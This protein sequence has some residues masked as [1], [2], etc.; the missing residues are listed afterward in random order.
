MAHSREK[1]G[2]GLPWTR[3]PKAL[4]MS[5]KDR[6]ERLAIRTSYLEAG[7]KVTEPNNPEVLRSF[8]AVRAGGRYGQ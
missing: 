8:P 7:Y 5:H 6:R 1:G 4:L 2:G 3:L